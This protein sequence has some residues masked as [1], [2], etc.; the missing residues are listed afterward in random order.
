MR[1]L[2]LGRAQTGIQAFSCAE[3]SFPRKRESRKKPAQAGFFLPQA[4]SVPTTR[5]GCSAPMCS[6]GAT[7]GRST[8][9]RRHKKEM[10]KRIEQEVTPLAT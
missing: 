4:K 6:S 2:I 1:A 10:R 7:S 9:W 3:T 5:R 8:D